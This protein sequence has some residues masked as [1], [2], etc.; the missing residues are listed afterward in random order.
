M[1]LVK[2][3]KNYI[4]YR[5]QIEIYGGKIFLM[6]FIKSLVNCHGVIEVNW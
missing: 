2:S 3:N 6:A 1:V 5:I 4:Y